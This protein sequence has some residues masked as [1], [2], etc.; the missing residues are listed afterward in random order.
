MLARSNRDYRVTQGDIYTLTYLA[1]TT[2]VV[3]HIIVD[4]SYRIRVSNLGIVNGA[5]K[6]FMQIKSEIEAIVS[7]NFPLS[8]AQLILTQ[9]AVFRIHVN[10]EVKRAAE[11]SAWALNRLSSLLNIDGLLTDMASIRNV[12]VRNADG[13]T[14]VYDLFRALRFGDMSQNPFLRPGDV[15]TFN[16]INR[17]GRI[18]RFKRLRR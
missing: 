3:Y 7:N 18:S 2:E 1:G 13:Q 5:G 17:I 6:T 8:G 12:T 10:G 4:P 15:V 16:R 14:H 9:P 11:I